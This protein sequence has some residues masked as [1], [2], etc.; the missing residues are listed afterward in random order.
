MAK[1]NNDQ[2]IKLYNE[3]K[4]Y[5]E[6]AEIIGCNPN[7]ISL[8]I[9]KLGIANRA[10]NKDK[11]AVHV[12]KPTEK[13]SKQLSKKELIE[14]FKIET[15]KLSSIVRKEKEIKDNDKKL[16]Y[17]TEISKSKV[18]EEKKEKPKRKQRTPKVKKEEKEEVQQEPQAQEENNV[19]NIEESDRKRSYTKNGNPTMKNFEDNNEYL[20]DYFTKQ[21]MDT[22]GNIYK[23]MSLSEI[24]HELMKDHGKK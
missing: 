14:Q 18:V 9:S 13:K 23:V 11:K 19:V 3:G 10:N 5:K 12:E 8:K 6:I 1:Y 2:I 21:V 16:L 20:V 17:S 7:Y 15:A 24:R 22:E 4:T